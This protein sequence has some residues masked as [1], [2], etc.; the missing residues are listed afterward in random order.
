MTKE[1][2]NHKNIFILCCIALSVTAM[3]FAIRAGI[4]GE[5]GANFGLSSTELG[6]I[7]SMAFLG[8][9]IAT[10]FGGFFYNTLGAKK[11]IT[12]A[13]FSHLLGLGLTIVAGDFWGLFISSLFV[14][15]ANGSVEAACNPLIADS[16]T[17]NKSTMLNKFHVWFPAGIVIGALVSKFMTDAGLGWQIQIAFMLIPTL[18]YG[19]MIFKSAFPTFERE[20]KSTTNNFKALFSPLF[21]FMI[22]CMTLTATTELATGQWINT[23]LEASGASPMLALAMITGLM[24]VLR[25][26]AGPVI[27]KFNTTGVLLFSAIFATIGLYLLSV[28]T[29][30]MTYLSAIIFAIGITYFW[31]TMLGFVAENNHE[32]GALGLS[33]M[34]GAGMF[35]VSMWNPVVGGWIDKAKEK[36]LSAVTEGVDPDLIAGQ[37]VLSTLTTFPIILIFAFGGLYFY[38]RNRNAN[39]QENTKE[40]IETQIN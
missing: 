30:T 5:L 19:M 35:A 10:I 22:I 20:E 29:G 36:A 27:N 6:W 26:F 34:G 2:V 12:L 4:L 28:T 38:M 39:K 1:K 40:E 15:F 21:I 31:P 8:F 37:A 24:A 18:I 23:I 9:P 33:M 3:T 14:G 32:T 13:F 7:N 17:K 11:L 16:Y 25:Y